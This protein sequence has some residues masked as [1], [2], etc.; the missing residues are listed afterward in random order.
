[1]LSTILLLILSL[2][3][4]LAVLLRGFCLFDFRGSLFLKNREDERKKILVPQLDP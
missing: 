4:G 1:M 3:I 2:F